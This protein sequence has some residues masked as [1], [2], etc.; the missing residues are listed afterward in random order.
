ML[1]N[2]LSFFF[3]QIKMEPIFRK[4]TL[5]GRFQVAEVH[6]PKHLYL[7]N[8]FFSHFIRK[9]FS[10]QSESWFFSDENRTRTTLE[11]HSTKKKN[12]NL[13][14]CCLAT[15][16]NEKLHKNLYI[17]YTHFRYKLWY[18]RMHFKPSSN[19]SR[20]FNL[21]SFHLAPPSLLIVFTFAFAVSRNF[22][23]NYCQNVLMAA[24]NPLFFFY[25]FDR[26][27]ECFNLHKLNFLLFC[28]NFQ[29]DMFICNKKCSFL[30]LFF[31]FFKS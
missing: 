7:G 9:L 10:F 16:W 17:N 8:M 2:V 6:V 22:H 18:T 20:H 23:F 31:F 19:F 30:Q 5:I 26:S 24:A 28:F 13:T 3:L 14:R 29:F 1:E 21:R 4:L 12:S 11:I 15:K 25:L 27:L